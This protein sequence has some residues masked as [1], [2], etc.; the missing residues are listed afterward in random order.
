MIR[1]E[2]LG[3]AFVPGQEG[4]LRLYRRGEEFSIRADGLELMNSRMHGSEDALADLVCA[5]LTDRRA[6]RLLIG[7]LGLGYTLATA[8][9]HLDKR[10]ARVDVAELVPAVVEWNRGVLADLA[11]R[12][13]ADKRVTVHIM[14]VARLMRKEQQAFDAILLDVDNGP[15]GLT[16]QSNSW[17]YGHAGLHTAY[18]A[19]RP[20]GILAIWSAGPN[21]HFARHLHLV[22]FT[23]EEFP[24]R[25]RDG[26]KG[27]HHLIWLATRP[28][29]APAT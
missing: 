2:L 24:V 25:G 28:A 18:A 26:H 19:L 23:V 4:E 7:G 15:E 3:K 13:L 5:R 17:L 20:R 1:W 16:R 8:L 29:T 10:A 9:R 12:P 21:A 22:G 6:A 11:G 27:G 14:D